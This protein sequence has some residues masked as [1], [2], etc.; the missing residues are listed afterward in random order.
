[1]YSSK[2]KKGIGFSPSTIG[3]LVLYNIRI[4]PR[5]TNRLGQLDPDSESSLLS[6]P[7][8]I[9]SLPPL[10]LGPSLPSFLFVSFLLNPSFT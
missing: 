1:M 8:F 2:L 9:P 6:L 4:L 5:W 7:A 3:L 10:P